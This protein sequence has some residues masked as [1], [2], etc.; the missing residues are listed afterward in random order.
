MFMYQ[1]SLFL[2]SFVSSILLL[3][4]I[5]I[6][7]KVLDFFVPSNLSHKFSILLYLLSIIFFLM[8]VLNFRFKITLKKDAINYVLLIISLIFSLII[9]EFM[10]AKHFHDVRINSII[11]NQAFSDM[12]KK[13]LKEEFFFK[14]CYKKNSIYKTLYFFNSSLNSD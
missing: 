8:F 9:F 12:G 5:L 14:N 10:T 11:N 6:F 2:K 4:S 1:L 3:I 7:P 13:I